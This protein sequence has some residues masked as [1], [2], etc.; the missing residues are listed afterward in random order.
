MSWAYVECTECNEQFEWDWCGEVDVCP[1]C[2][3]VDTLE[4]VEEPK[5]ELVYSKEDL[6]A[7]YLYE[8]WKDDRH[9]H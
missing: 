3:S 6:R 8:V 2:R 7:D 4:E 9:K 5:L 1:H